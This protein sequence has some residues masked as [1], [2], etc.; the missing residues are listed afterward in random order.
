VLDGL[1]TAS[2]RNAAV[3]Q[4]ARAFIE[5]HLGPGDLAAVFSPGASSQATEDFTGDK[6]RLLSAVDRFTGTK[7]RSYT[8]E[9]ASQAFGLGGPRG[10]ERMGADSERAYRVLALTNVLESLAQHLDRIRGRRKALLLFSEGF[11]YDTGDVMGKYQRYASEVAHAMS[12]AVNALMRTNTV[13]YTIDPRGLATAEADLVADPIHEIAPGNPDNLSERDFQQEVERSV[14]SLRD[15][16]RGTGGFFANDKGMTRAFQQIIEETSD[17]YMIRYSPL[18]S[19]RPGESRRIR[20]RISRP[21]VTVVAR[22]GYT[23]PRRGGATA[24]VD[25]PGDIGL[26]QRG[27]PPRPRSGASAAMKEPTMRADRIARIRPDLANLLESPLPQG[28]L[29]IRVQAVPFWAGENR[30]DVQLVIEVLGSGLEFVERAGR[31]EERLELAFLTVDATGRAANGRSTT[32]ELRLP[33]TERL[34]VQTTGVRWL[35]NLRLEAGWYQLRVAGRAEVT[36]VTGLV[37]HMFEVPRFVR[38]E[39]SISGVLITSLPS[40]LGL[41]RGETRLERTLETPPSAAR[42]FVAGDRLSA[43]VELYAPT[44]MKTPPA[45]VAAVEAVDGAVLLMSGT[46]CAPSSERAQLHTHACKV[47]FE[48]GALPPGRYVLRVGIPGGGSAGERRVP[49]DVVASH[50]QGIVNQD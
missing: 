4:Q 18:R 7:L 41:T 14:W 38:G 46:D 22:R 32:I 30:L 50:A 29:P 21:N 11:D 15:L 13:L 27:A 44:S 10:K 35:S 43:A 23:V 6:A 39:L 8:Q 40:V 24:S 49:F 48:T 9:A 47:S 19:A 16:A 42:T 31:A 45:V 34:Q 33:P 5:E 26:P 12:R 17:Y 1:H 3:R 20:V 28:G 36:G 37:T 2:H 25:L